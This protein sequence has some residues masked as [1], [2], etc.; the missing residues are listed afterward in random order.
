M[1]SMG[2]QNG[3]P[4]SDL[5]SFPLCYNHERL[6]DSQALRVANQVLLSVSPLSRTLSVPCQGAS[7]EITAVSVFVSI[8]MSKSG[9]P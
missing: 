3:M 1:V 4:I 8:R 7:F 5:L 9:S 2:S 6:V